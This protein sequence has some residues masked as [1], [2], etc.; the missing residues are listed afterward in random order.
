LQFAC[1]QFTEG[2]L[3]Q[4]READ[5]ERTFNENQRNEK[6]AVVLSVFLIVK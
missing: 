2:T 4:V 1:S 3:Q 6:E 5:N